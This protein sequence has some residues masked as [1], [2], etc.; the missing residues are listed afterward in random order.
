MTQV[1]ER[2]RTALIVLFFM[3]LPVTSFPYFPPSFGGNSAVVRPLLVYP[4]LGL[5]F[6]ITLPRLFTNKLSQPILVLLIFVLWAV[7][8]SIIPLILGVTS[9][10]Q[11]VEVL[12]REIRTI[13]TL[14]L[15]FSI[16]LTTALINRSPRDL[17]FSVRWIYAGL[18]MALLWGSLQA[19]Y[20]LDIL[21]GWYE[22][23][24]QLQGYLS[25]HRLRPNRI[26]GMTY[27]PTWFADQIVIMWL[28]L[29]LAASF[30]EET[31]FNWRW[32]WI[33]VEKILL[34]WTMGILAFT[35]SRTGL[36]LG[37]G[38]FVF[39]LILK[40][41]SPLPHKVAGD[42]TPDKSDRVSRRASSPWNGQSRTILIGIGMVIFLLLF[43]Y[44]GTQSGY[45]SRIWGYWF[46][47]GEK[48]VWQYFTYIGFGSRI[49]YWRTAY[50]IFVEHPLFGIG[51][52]NFTIY[53]PEMLPDQHLA[54]T[55]E[56]LR[57]LVPQQGRSRVLTAK[58]FLLRVL[59]ETGL[60]G[61]GI[62]FTFLLLLL[63]GGV[64]LW[65]SRDRTE[66]FWGTVS[67]IGVV[68][69]VGDAFSFDSFAIPNP[70]I[71][72]GLITSAIGVYVSGKKDEET[73]S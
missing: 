25:I 71:L 63:A 5:V 2:V 38:L 3:S 56:L 32:K 50:N 36:V 8:A 53:F 9:P 45:I 43:V 23:M 58:H 27:E 20:V 44:L 42:G 17:Q 61:G 51:L 70:W 60:I 66:H 19:I 4:L 55:P 62:F 33:T 26:S 34:V 39:G 52:G 15:G 41:L 18:V 14:A 73:Q 21:P 69:F 1:I 65:L 46:E 22:V 13:I 40:I 47:G 7:A 49:A 54:R 11:E 16:F 10:W 35:L 28:P 64:Y 6:L 59:A 12:S 72:F 68:A 30:T 31:I 57:H 37:V 67:L 29:V 24:N 48:N